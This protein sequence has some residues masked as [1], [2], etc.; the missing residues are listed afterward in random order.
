M[1]CIPVSH[2]VQ[3]FSKFLILRGFNNV[4]ILKLSH[5][6]FFALNKISVEKR[7]TWQ[8]SS[9]KGFIYILNHQVYNITTCLSS[10]IFIGE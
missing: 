8:W 10:I 1:A 7:V 9:D 5:C 3:L 4:F 2:S 6:L